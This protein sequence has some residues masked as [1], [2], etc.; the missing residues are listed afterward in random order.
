MCGSTRDKE[1][2]WEGAK[3]KKCGQDVKYDFGGKVYTGNQIAELI[4]GLTKSV[5]EGTLAG[6]EAVIVALDMV[7]KLP[8]GMG[9]NLLQALL[10]I[11]RPRIYITPL[12]R[13]LKAKPDAYAEF[14]KY[15]VRDY[16]LDLVSNYADEKSCQNV[17][18]LNALLDCLADSRE[19]VSNVAKAV[20]EELKAGSN[21]DQTPANISDIKGWRKWQQECSRDVEKLRE[22]I[23]RNKG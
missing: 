5:A 7:E 23:R 15:L 2:V 4:M 19:S 14:A 8:Q 1:H 3:C 11:C 18:G 17:A 22:E 16:T 6:Q 12:Y 10:F 9:W 21:R 13:R 20:F